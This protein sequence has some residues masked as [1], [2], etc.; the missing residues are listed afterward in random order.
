M[1]CSIAFGDDAD[2]SGIALDPLKIS[3]ILHKAYI[4]VTHEGT[5]AAA[6]TAT[7]MTLATCCM[8]NKRINFTVD[9]PFMFII[10]DNNTILFHG[11]CSNP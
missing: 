10:K 7:T 1:D 9:K 4:D 2:F 11:K 6:A 8:P 3:D 5:E